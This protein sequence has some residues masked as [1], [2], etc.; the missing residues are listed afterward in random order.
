M[1]IAL[2][3]A[4]SFSEIMEQITEAKVV[5]VGEVH[6]RYEDHLLQLRVIRT[7]FAQN[8]NL[9]IGMEMFSREA[10]PFLDR[11]VAGEL[12]EREFLKQSRYFSKWGFDYRL[13][14]EIINFARHNKLPIVA[15]NQEKE[16]VSKVFK[17]GASA[18]TA[19]EIA[20]L[21]ADRDLSIPGYRQRIAEVF[22]MHGENG[23]T[24]EQLNGFFQAQAIWDETMAD[25]V[26]T[27]LNAN[28]ESRIVVLAGNGHTDKATA[29]PPRVARRL[30]TLRQSVIMNNTGGE[31][32]Q[33]EA[34]YL[35]FSRAYKLPPAALLGVML[36][37]TP[38]GLLVEGFSEQSKA[39]AAGILEKDV[40]LA[41]DDE[42]VPTIDDLKISML[43]KKTGT[44]L[45]VRV[46]RKS[47]ILF[48][49][50]S[51]LSIPVVL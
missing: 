36:A 17:E 22:A 23:Y 12:D 28:P 1:G 9:A 43:Y 32:E 5:Y 50:E 26:V 38:E 7:L 24:R 42:P 20:K 27:F 25:S 35:I 8:Q 15:L 2:P 21:P 33:K 19:E 37:G 49:K 41:L 3:K 34:D 48:K 51:I 4:L 45:T 29:I 16:I 46:K 47:G 39:A 13:Y 31:L 10:Q 6:N 14:R 18:L 44:P 40:I 11:Y 30:P